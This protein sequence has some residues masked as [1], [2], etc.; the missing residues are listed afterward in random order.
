[1]D[2]IELKSISGAVLLLETVGENPLL[3]FSSFQRLSE[4]LGLWPHHSDLCIHHHI[5]SPS[6]S[7]F[8]SPSL[9]L[10]FL[11]LLLYWVHVDNPR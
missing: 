4:F 1:M 3:A 11:P 9:A 5:S 8:T 2:L 7:A 6:T 10:T